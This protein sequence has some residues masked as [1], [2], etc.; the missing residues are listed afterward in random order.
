MPDKSYTY[1]EAEFELLRDLAFNEA[2]FSRQRMAAMLDERRDV[3][4]ECRLPAANTP[5]DAW[6]L[7]DLFR[8]EAIA[9]RVVELYA[10]ESWRKS[11]TVF[12]DPDPDTITEFEEAWDS[13][14]S[15]LRGEDSSFEEEEGSPIWEYL[16]RADILS[17]IGGYGVM[18][19]GFDDGIQDLSQP[20]GGA[21]ELNSFPAKLTNN[22]LEYVRGEPA[23]FARYKLTVNNP[24]KRRQLRYIRCFPEC[25]AQVTQW[26]TNE[27]SPRY[28]MP[29]QYLV[30]FNDYREGVAGIGAPLGTRSVHW[31]RVIHLTDKWECPSA[32]EVVSPSRLESVLN[33]VL[34]LQK[35]YCGNGEA[36]W[37]NAF[38]KTT[39]STHAQLGGQV[40]MNETKF[41]EMLDA[42]REGSQRDMILKGLTA[43]N[44]APTMVDPTPHIAAHMEVIAV[45]KGCPLRV[46][47]G[48]ERGE[49][50]SQQDDIN[51]DGRLDNRQATYNTPREI[52]PLA[53]R[54]IAFNVLPKPKKGYRI[55]WPGN[56]DQTA[57]EQATLAST[58]TATYAAYIGGNVQTLI[59]P[60]DFL[61]EI[62]HIDEEKAQ[63]ILENAAAEQEDPLLAPEEPEIPEETEVPEETEGT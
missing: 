63:S 50:S 55:E 2:T 43:A 8:R 20:V 62:M 61:T 13:L 11:P 57:Q 47:K 40:K 18:L 33:N 34:A 27:L 46:L 36:Y 19:L 39:Y 44:L 51:W 45:R 53:D 60:K 54:L 30:T 24:Q 48:A 3:Y 41:K 58:N 6:A 5:L 56:S 42:V 52:V 9:A 31:T 38:P 28:S 49:L 14:G 26:E 1:S 23:N 22:V 7:Y 29:V 59:P 10:K 4:K 17:G 37:Q 16:L 25:Q 21:S 32:N 15:Q 12:E 35:L